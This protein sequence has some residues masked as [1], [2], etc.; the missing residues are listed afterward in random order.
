MLHVWRGWSKGEREKEKN[1]V[2]VVLVGCVSP[3][4]SDTKKQKHRCKE[5]LP[6][7]QTH[8]HTHKQIQFSEQML[9]QKNFS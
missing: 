3:P 7:I 2:V 6:L 5:F 4:Q 9:A 8:T 1:D